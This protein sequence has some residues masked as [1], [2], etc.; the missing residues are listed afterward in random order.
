MFAANREPPSVARINSAAH[1]CSNAVS[2]T[3]HAG[4]LGETRDGKLGTV[5]SFPTLLQCRSL[6]IKSLIL[7]NETF[8]LEIDSF[9]LDISGLTFDRQNLPC[10]SETFPFDVKRATAGMKRLSVDRK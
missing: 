8:T 1:R 9:S 7:D 6:E 3:I 4:K 5:T 2:R 10:E